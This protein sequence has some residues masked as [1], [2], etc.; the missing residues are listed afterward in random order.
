MNTRDAI[1]E[2][3]HQIGL[4][5]YEAKLYVAL[6]NGPSTHLRLAQATGINRT[7]VYRL[8]ED[9]EKRGLI[10]R[11]AD[12]SGT[13][14]VAADPSTLEIAIVDAERQVRRQREALDSA[15]PTLQ[16]I[17]QGNGQAF[18]IHTYE[19]SEG[20]K[21]MLWHELKTEGEAL[22]FGSGA[23][24]DLVDD[25]HWAEKHR[26]KTI[27]ADYTLREINNP[28]GKLPHPASKQASAHMSHKRIISPSVLQLEHQIV[29]YN[30][31]V[32]TYHWRKQQKVGSEIVSASYA[33]M[34]RQVF[35]NFWDLA[36]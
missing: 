32:A 6:L 35:E 29:I 22:I 31:T 34:M 25:H 15:M 27:E 14:L 4:G 3:L 7:K 2:K 20:F 24:E 16:A 18:V 10:R 28:H 13:Y 8:A 36:E 26:I 9:L 1:I 11:Q 33:H 21:Q 23:I 17:Q 5:H 19:G 30:T 12:D